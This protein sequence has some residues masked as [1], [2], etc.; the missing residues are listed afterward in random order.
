[1][2]G[3]AGSPSGG[4]AGAGDE[5]NAG[6]GGVEAESGAAGKA[7]NAGNGGAG[8]SDD[9][10]SGAGGEATGGGGAGGDGASGASGA[11]GAGG[12]GG[13]GSSVIDQHVH[14]YISN[15]CDVS[16]DPVDITIPAGQ[17]VFF[18]F[19]NHSSDYNA[20]VW[21]SYGG[22]YLG[23]PEG[24]TWDDP[25]ERCAEA[26]AYTAYADISIEGLGVFDP[27]C[28]GHRM[29]IYCQ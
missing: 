28:P 12:A 14:I 13:A 17:S 27:T 24:S 4:A 25:I 20:T 21:N 26:F 5:D 22:G 10:A 18:S 9:A 6:A 29:Y 7:D 3:S 19:H 8:G 15:F 11:S 23:L 16:V 2:S 1:M